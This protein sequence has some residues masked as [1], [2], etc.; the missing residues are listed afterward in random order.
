MKNSNEFE[1]IAPKI[2]SF[3]K[4]KAPDFQCSVCKKDNFTVV[5]AF[6]RH[7]FQKTLKSLEFPGISVPSVSLVC[8]NCGSIYDFSLKVIG[9]EDSEGISKFIIEE[10]DSEKKAKN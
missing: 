7:E 5:G 3:I 8:D 2:I 6:H 4:E 1:K 9:I 10:D